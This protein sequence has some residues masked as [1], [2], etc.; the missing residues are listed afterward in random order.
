MKILETIREKNGVKLRM[1]VKYQTGISYATMFRKIILSFYPFYTITGIK[2]NDKA[3]LSK[4]FFIGKHSVWS[5]KSSLEKN[6]IFFKNDENIKQINVTSISV[7]REGEIF[8]NAENDENLTKIFDSENP[9]TLE[10]RIEKVDNFYHDQALITDDYINISPLNVLDT[11]N[12]DVQKKT[13]DSLELYDEID[14]HV[15]FNISIDFLP[16]IEDELVAFVS[17]FIGS[18]FITR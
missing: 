10:M 12:F 16:D 13:G 6:A 9:F 11:V 3:D 15:N 1:K 18:N 7:N 8:F 2:I 17:E 4:D 5:L 14:M